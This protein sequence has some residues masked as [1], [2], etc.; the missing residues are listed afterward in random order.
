MGDPTTAFQFVSNVV[1]VGRAPACI[2]RRYSCLLLQQR[3][4]MSRIDDFATTICAWLCTVDDESDD[5]HRRQA[6]IE[7]DEFRGEVYRVG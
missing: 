3:Y 2:A 5:L 6:W 1:L 7:R 4:R